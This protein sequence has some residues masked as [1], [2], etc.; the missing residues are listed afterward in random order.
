MTPVQLASALA[1][2]ANLHNE[3]V[4][5]RHLGQGESSNG[6]L[7]DTKNSQSKLRDGHLWGK[8]RLAPDIAKP[9]GY[10]RGVAKTDSFIHSELY[11]SK[12]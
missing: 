6:E 2:D 12:T 3:G 1:Q 10:L 9:A 11:S 5:D 7:A 4:G 8:T